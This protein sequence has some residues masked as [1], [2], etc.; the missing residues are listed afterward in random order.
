MSLVLS[1]TL[2]YRGGGEFRPLHDFFDSSALKH[3]IRWGYGICKSKYLHMEDYK[4][5]SGPKILLC[6]SN[7]AL[8]Q[9]FRPQNDLAPHIYRS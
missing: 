2:F 7:L 9:K 3:R 5:V 1:T 4:K 6:A 8:K